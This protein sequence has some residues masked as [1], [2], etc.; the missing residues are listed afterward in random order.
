MATAVWL[1][2]AALS[3]D[4]CAEE[5]LG[6]RD[7]ERWAAAIEAAR[8]RPAE[9]GGFDS[10]MHGAI[11]HSNPEGVR[12][13]ASAGLCGDG[14]GATA[15]PALFAALR[16][17]APYPRAEDVA[18]EGS[19][20][21]NLLIR[22]MGDPGSPTGRRVDGH[23]WVPPLTA[24]GGGGD[25]GLPPFPSHGGWPADVL[26]RRRWRLGA[27]RSA[28]LRHLA[29]SLQERPERAPFVVP[30]RLLHTV[31]REAVRCARPA[32]AAA[33][34]P[35]SLARRRP[36]IEAYLEPPSLC[37][38]VA[39]ASVDRRT[40]RSAMHAAAELGDEWLLR[41]LLELGAA[42]AAVDHSGDV[43]AAHL[44]ARQGFWGAVGVLA[45]AQGG[46]AADGTE[47]LLAPHGAAVAAESRC[48][49]GSSGGGWPSTEPMEVGPDV[50][51]L[52]QVAAADIDPE[53][54][55][56]QFVA[57][58]RPVRIVG[59]A[60]EWGVAA[61]TVEA[62]TTGAAARVELPTSTVPYASV[63][64]GGA[65]EPLPLGTFVRQ[66]ANG[67]LGCAADA[68]GCAAP[69]VFTELDDPELEVLTPLLRGA[70]RPGLLEAAADDDHHRPQLYVGPPGSAAPMHFHGAAVNAL[71]YGR[72]RWF[73]APPRIANFS[74]EPG[75]YWYRS[76]VG[77]PRP[78]R[79]S[80]SVRLTH[81]SGQ[82]CARA[83]AVRPMARGC[84]LRAWRLGPRR[85][86]RAGERWRG[87]QFRG[88][89]SHILRAA[90]QAMPVLC[91]E[92]SR[93][94]TR[95]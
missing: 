1:L 66:V 14:A 56:T 17:S 6:A 39:A 82:A 81:P 54:F 23:T 27:E 18:V 61:L 57:A 51:E 91:D 4:L 35:L 32:A 36:L 65:L 25:G 2:A 12:A 59:G 47:A 19:G 41:R 80:P 64:G 76:A 70:L 20:W 83:I 74:T 62:L 38:G 45:E 24:G 72:K 42:P 22:A 58:G 87:A 15:T 92:P 33:A 3:V 78:R 77:A 60:A 48:T 73:L 69:Y 50:C 49:A 95:S 52:P 5:L 88:R 89:L 11:A 84:H 68:A 8:T 16:A 34:P 31:A 94:M 67:S 79:A 28:S 63:Y 46:E 13:L 7:A 86:E 93:S 29:R 75:T 30:A 9:C 71:A 55:A 21:T 43:T 53:R 26:G 37:G 44:A 10:A 85:L 40:G 90:A